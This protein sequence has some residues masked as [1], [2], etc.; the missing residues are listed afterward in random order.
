MVPLS[1]L[2]NKFLGDLIMSLSIKSA[3]EC[4]IVEF[5]SKCQ[6]GKNFFE[7]CIIFNITQ[8]Q[9]SFVF[10]TLHKYINDYFLVVVPLLSCCST[11]DSKELSSLV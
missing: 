5:I 3:P 9:N 6:I 2:L 11:Q 7:L 1:D 4:I 10:F 8:I